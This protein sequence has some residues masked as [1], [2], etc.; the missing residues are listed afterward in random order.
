[1]DRGVTGLIAHELHTVIR[2]EADTTFVF[3]V[4]LGQKLAAR[5]ENLDARERH[6]DERKQILR[7]SEQRP[8]RVQRCIRVEQ[9]DLASTT[10]VGRSERCLCQSGFK[11]EHCPGLVGRR[12]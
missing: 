9:P 3:A 4:K 7:A 5:A 6:L 12:A 1:M 10:K 2:Q 8:R 11:Y